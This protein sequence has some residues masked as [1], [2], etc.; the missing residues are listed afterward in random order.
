MLQN[1]YD[2]TIYHAASLCRYMRH[3]TQYRFIFV[4]KTI[5]TI[6]IMYAQYVARKT[7]RITDRQ[8]LHYRIYP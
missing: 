8:F 4:S 6:R 7:S 2:V 3:K 5:N 1:S